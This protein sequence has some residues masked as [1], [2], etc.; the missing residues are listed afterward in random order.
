MDGFVVEVLGLVVRWLHVITGIAWVGASF[1]FIWLDNSL[2]EPPQW[3]KDQG[4]KGDLWS[5]HGGGIYE[6]AKY[7][8]G[9][10]Q[11]PGRLHWFYWEA[12]S[13][14]ITGMLLLLVVYY[15]QA[16]AYLLPGDGP[17]D[18]PALGIAASLAFIA[19]GYIAYNVML[20]AGLAERVPVFVT[21]MIVLLTF[22][23]WLSVQLF[24]DRAAYVHMGIVIGTI[25]VANVFFGIIPPQR[26]FV[27]AIEGGQELPTE[28]LRMAKLRSM[29]NNYLT[30]PVLFA[31]ISNHYP[32]LYGHRYSWLI[33]ILIMMITAGAR[34]F[35]NLRHKGIYKPSI[36]VV[37]A[38]LFVALM[39]AIGWD[40]QKQMEA[41]LAGPVLAESDAMALIETH[42]GACHA[43]SPTFPGMT[44]A[45]LGV[46][47]ESPDL[48]TQHAAKAREAVA[49]R[50]M[51]LGNLTQL[52]DD[53]RQQLVSWLARQAS[54]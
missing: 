12:Y 45:P 1:Y 35:F 13:T 33:L 4:I 5:F 32:F 9:P 15:F 22:L 42:C 23:S 51:P 28:G 48:I 47:L 7:A 39:M 40:R 43:Q 8:L 3:K 41:E 19:S 11:M 17:L 38:I 26:E 52:S 30:L 2:D 37:A 27:R 53:E 10:K 50:Y 29:H 25:M 44:A 16:S 6:V 34:Q 24:S 20:K 49:T 36:L 14:W 46:V 31:M 21:C 54:H 18:T